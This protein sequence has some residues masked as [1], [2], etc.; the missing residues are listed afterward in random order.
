MAELTPLERLQPCLLDRL[1]D[2]EP[3]R[4]QESRE[5]R[6]MSMARYRQ[7]VLRDLAWLLNTPSHIESDGLEEFE[8][9]PTSVINFGVRDVAGMSLSGMSADDVERHMIA[10]IRRFEPRVNPD[11]LTV[12]TVVDAAAMSNRAIQIEVTGDLWAQP[13]PEALYIKTE[14][15]LETG[16]CRV[17][18][19]TYG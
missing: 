5:R 16:E 10:A 9:V 14:V 2:D 8:E 6:V 11:S 13:V 12:R 4:K 15:D 19:G 3:H 17:N 1:T 7:A 18:Q